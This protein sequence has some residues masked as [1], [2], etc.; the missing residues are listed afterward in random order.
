MS[1]G[2]DKPPTRA[3][4]DA[5]DVLMWLYARAGHEVSYADISAGVGLPDG[6]R[7]RTAV[8]RVRVAAAH[9][10][11]RLEQFMRSKDPLRRGAMTARFHRAG[12]GDDLGFRDALLACR[13]SVASM[14]EMQR[15]C[16]FEATNP[17]SP[18]ADAFSKMAET[19]DGAMRMVSGVEGLGS[20]V[21]KNQRTMTR[22]AER[23]ADLEA[24]VVQLSAHPPAASA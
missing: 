15:A 12:Q 9:D 11:H 8:R 4:Q 24:Q 3:E 22:M 23:I 16:A 19:A 18:D 6:S 13:K 21:M 14:A 2:E 10:G 1:R 5:V 17:S 7:L 20:K